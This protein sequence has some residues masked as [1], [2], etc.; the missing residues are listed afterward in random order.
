MFS[1]CILWAFFMNI[2][3]LIVT[4]TLFWMHKIST[5]VCSITH[6]LIPKSDL[7]KTVNLDHIKQFNKRSQHIVDKIGPYDLNSILH[8]EEGAFAVDPSI[9]T[10]IARSIGKTNEPIKMGQRDGLTR[11]DVQ[12]INRYYNCSHVESIV[13]KVKNA[14]ESG[15]TDL[16]VSKNV[17]VDEEVQMHSFKKHPKSYYWFKSA[18]DFLTRT[19]NQTLII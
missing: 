13:V 6:H 14:I 4:V 5:E 11:I 9:P 15:A 12:K 16:G 1:W 18:A 3:D 2:L 7:N 10:I 19:G 17:V 8:Y